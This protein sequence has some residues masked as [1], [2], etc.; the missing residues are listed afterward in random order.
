MAAQT[1]AGKPAPDTTDKPGWLTRQLGDFRTWR[2]TITDHPLKGAVFAIVLFVLGVLG[3]E[4]ADRV[5]QNFRKPDA[6]LVQMKD[7]Q[8][9]N[10]DALKTS[11]SE[12]RGSLDGNGNAALRN[13]ASAAEALQHTNARLIEEFALAKRENETLRKA[14]RDSTGMEGGSD[15]IVGESGSWQIDPE[16]SIGLAGVNNGYVSINL[17]S[18][19]AE[20]SVRENLNVGEAITY[21]SASGQACKIALHTINNARPGSASFSRICRAGA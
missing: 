9:Q 21:T 19:D 5:M 18:R 14:V 6:F 15:F 2:K 12:L 7:E 1:D 3:N 11:L 13:V 20:T 10:F 17:T 8:K 16:T 4:A